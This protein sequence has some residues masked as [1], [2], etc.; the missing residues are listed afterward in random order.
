MS[1]ISQSHKILCVALLALAVA[2]GYSPARAQLPELWVSLSD[3]NV[4]VGDTSAWISVYFQNYQDTLAGFAMRV[5]LDRPDI[6]EFRTDEEDTLIDTTWWECIQW[7]GSNCVDSVPLDPPYIDTTITNMGI[8]TSGSVISNWEYVTARSLTEGRHDIKVT[9]LAEATS[10]PPYNLGL[11][12]QTSPQLLFR[13]RVRIYDTLPDDDSTVTLYIIDNLSE[14]NFSD[15]M[16]NL[17]GTVTDYNMRDS[18][19]CE[20]WD[21]SGDSCLTGCLSEDPGVYD[22]LVLDT[23]FRWWVCTEWGQDSQGGD[24]CLSWDSYSIFDSVPGGLYDSLSVDSIPWTVWNEETTLI[25]A[26][27]VLNV[28]EIACVCGD[29]NNDELTNV[30]DPV[31][32]IQYIF[33]GGE[34]PAYPECSDVNSDGSVDVGDVVYLINWIFR[35]GA[36]PNC[37]F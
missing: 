34:Y 26:E 5:V 3:T 7:S 11:L 23:F 21:Y 28:V 35:D 4:A 18:C 14:T 17:I 30:G 19:Y 9:G 6:M 1:F 10:G 8:D 36:D 37:G 16:G 12:P 15:P 13:M 27:G 20:T 29:A 33:K 32:L 22:T 2:A 25:D 31:F 24:S